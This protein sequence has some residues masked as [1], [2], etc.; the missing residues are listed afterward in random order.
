MTDL[1]RSGIKN[2]VLF[3]GINSFYVEYEG[4]VVTY[5]TDEGQKKTGKVKTIITFL[6]NKSAK[7]NSTIAKVHG[8]ARAPNPENI[9]IH[10]NKVS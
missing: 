4:E 6:C 8:G 2:I 10:N 3:I 9:S 7:W 5:V 1:L